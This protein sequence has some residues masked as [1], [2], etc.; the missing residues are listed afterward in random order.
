L[1]LCVIDKN[2]SKRYT[3]KQGVTQ[4]VFNPSFA[5]ITFPFIYCTG[6]QERGCYSIAVKIYK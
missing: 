5:L 1:R 6:D 3:D 2:I 4:R